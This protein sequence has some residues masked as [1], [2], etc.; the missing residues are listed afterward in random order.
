MEVHEAKGTGRL[1]H[2][3]LQNC[4]R[5]EGEALDPAALQ[6]L[7]TSVDKQPVL[8]YPAH[9]HDTAVGMAPMHAPCV[10]QDPAR[11]RLVVLDATWRKSRKM[12]HLNPLLQALPRYVLQDQ[13]TSRYSIRKAHQPDQLSTLEA[14][15]TAL[16]QIECS[17][18]P[19]AP[20]LR[21]FDGFVA[22]QAAYQAIHASAQN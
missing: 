16:A 21:A 5:I 12:L 17:N 13:P 20:L 19:F 11:L 6:A 1:L 4:Q 22:Q 10:W 7:L 9:P 14:V 3:S 2:L 15:C 18:Q 8:L